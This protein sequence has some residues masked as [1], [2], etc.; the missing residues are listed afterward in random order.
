ME[1]DKLMKFEFDKLFFILAENNISRPWNGARKSR[2]LWKGVGER[3]STEGI[4]SYNKIIKTAT[5]K[6][7]AKR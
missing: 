1:L 6:N 7:A 5:V 3:I 4:T 2:E